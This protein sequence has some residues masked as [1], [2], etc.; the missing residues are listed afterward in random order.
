MAFVLSTVMDAIAAELTTDISGIRVAGYPIANP[1]PPYAIVGYPTEFQYD[2]TAHAIGTTG[3]IRAVF[4]VRYVVG[5][6]IE[7]ATRDAISALVTGSP[8]IPESLG[9]SLGS[10]VDT[11]NVGDAPRFEV[12]NI[13]GVDYQAVVFDLE[14]IG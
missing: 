10:V 5:R 8:G 3:K 1:T 7:K 13:A 14:V 12:E 2:Y 11:A 4:P 6:V 9:G